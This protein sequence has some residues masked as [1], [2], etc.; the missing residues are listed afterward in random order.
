MFL[1]SSAARRGASR[2]RVRLENA[3]AARNNGGWPHAL[4]ERGSRLSSNLCRRSE[5]AAVKMS[6]T[7][8][9]L[10]AAGNNH[11]LPLHFEQVVF[12]RRIVCSFRLPFERAAVAGLAWY[13]C[14][15]LSWPWCAL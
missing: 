15:L 3:I 7:L 14:R 4:K 8:D 2:D 6:E 12:P 13:S 11:P 1:R 10:M 9:Q 5:F